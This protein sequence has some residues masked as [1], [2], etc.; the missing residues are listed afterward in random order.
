[1]VLAKEVDITNCRSVAE[2]KNYLFNLDAQFFREALAQLSSNHPLLKN[3][4]TGRRYYVMSKLFAGAV[5]ELL[6][7]HHP[8][9][10]IRYD[11]LF[12]WH[13]VTPLPHK[14]LLRSIS[15]CIFA[16]LTVE[17]CISKSV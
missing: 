1:M 13:A 6:Q 15:K 5:E 2:A 8:L 3:D 9:R 7:T 17:R 12:H 16:V 10:F 11:E 14:P 4:G